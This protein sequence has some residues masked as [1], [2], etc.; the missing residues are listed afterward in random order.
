[1]DNLN[2]GST[3]IH[4]KKSEAQLKAEFLIMFTLS[5][6]GCT[7]RGIKAHGRGKSDRLPAAGKHN[8]G[9]ND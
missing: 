9:M 3:K 8:S 1:M 4:A 6:R 7:W 5:G 2:L